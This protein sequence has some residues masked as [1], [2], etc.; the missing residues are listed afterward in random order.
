M[1][2]SLVLITDLNLGSHDEL[3]LGECLT[4]TCTTTTHTQRTTI[5][6]ALL[7]LQTMEI[8]YPL[9]HSIST[10]TVVSVGVTVGGTVVLVGDCGWDCGFS[11]CDWF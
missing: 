10:G 7:S 4:R 11:G 3:Y 8:P 1:Y 6:N 5:R 2:N 9:E